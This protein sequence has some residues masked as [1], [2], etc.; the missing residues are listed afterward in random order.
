LPKPRS[1]DDHLQLYTVFAFAVSEFDASTWIRIRARCAAFDEV[2]LLAAFERAQIR[3]RPHGYPVSS[4]AAALPDA[5][6]FPLRLLAGASAVFQTGVAFG[7]ELTQ[8]IPQLREPACALPPTSA[9]SPRAVRYGEADYR[10]NHTLDSLPGPSLGVRA[11]IHAAGAAVLYHD[12]LSDRDFAVSY[13]VV[14]PEL[15]FAELERRAI[16]V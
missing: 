7:F 15:S 8:L 12:F 11:A 1:F 16:V 10:I 3:A 13:E 9:I 5:L 14:A 6:P 4:M 2:S